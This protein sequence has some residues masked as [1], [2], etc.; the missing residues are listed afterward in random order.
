MNNNSII[1][2]LA[3]VLLV[4]VGGIGYAIWSSSNTGQVGDSQN[5]SV[6]QTTDNN[7][8]TTVLQAGAPVVKTDT[9]TAPYISTVVVKG[10]VNPNG[11]ITTYWY[12][13]GQTSSLGAKTSDYLVGSG[14]TTIYAPA[15][16]TGLLSDTN[17]SFRL[18]S[19][20]TFGTVN[21]QIYNFKTN[22]IPDPAGIA[23]DT[24]TTAATNITRTAANLNGKVNP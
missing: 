15:Y 16:I 20:N 6:T 11:A 17:Y 23:P 19:K 13:Y 8:S 4:T 22:T 1:S 5:S 9:N 7:N 3:I 12:E 2:L 10:T 14:Y 18:V 21:G 24:N